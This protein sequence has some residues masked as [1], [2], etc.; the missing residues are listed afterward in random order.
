MIRAYVTE[1]LLGM[2]VRI[3]IVRQ[4]EG[5]HLLSMLRVLDDDSTRFRWQQIEDSGI[6]MKPTL[7]LQRD[8]ARAMLDGLTRL[9]Q[10]AEDTRALRKDYDAERARVDALARALVDVTTNLTTPP[11]MTAGDVQGSC[12][13]RAK[14]TGGP[15]Q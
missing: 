11:L 15:S 2:A 3:S 13:W 6:E 1:D 8:E 9:F 14:P 5:D 12:A 10:G 4:V 7:T